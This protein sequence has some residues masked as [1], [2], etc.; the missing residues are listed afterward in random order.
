[1]NR[2]TI[3]S[4]W[5]FLF[6]LIIC[7]STT[8]AGVFTAED[9]LRTE[10]ISEVSISPDGK[11]V[12][13][14]ISKPRAASEKPGYPYREL[15]IY[16]ADKDTTRAFITGKGNMIDLKWRPIHHQLSFRMRRES[17]TTQIWMIPV[18]GGESVQ[19]S[20]SETSVQSYR[21]QPDGYRI[22]YVAPTPKTKKQKELEEKGYGFIFFEE[23]LRHRNLYL[24]DVMLNGNS[25]SPRQ[26]THDETVW[27]FEFNPDGSKML[28]LIS[29][30]NTVDQHH[31]FGKLHLLDMETLEQTLLIDNPGKMGMFRFSPDSR[32]IAFVGAKNQ[33]DHKESQLYC[34]QFKDGMIMNLTPQDYRGHVE[35]ADWQDD[36]TILYKSSEGVWSAL[37][38]VSLSDYKHKNLLH[39]K[40]LGL[41]FSSPEM[42]R[43]HKRMAFAG[44]SAEDPEQVY[45]YD[46]KDKPRAIT[47]I[48]PWM[49][50]KKLGEQQIIH[51]PAR[52]GYPVQ[53]LLIH[54]VI[55]PDS[56]PQLVVLV[57]GGPESHDSNDWITTY[58]RPGQALAGRGYLVFYP[59]YRSSTGYGL[60]HA[61]AGFGDPAGVEF[62]DI[63]DGIDYLVSTGRADKRRVGVAGSSYGG[64]A[65]AWFGT[66]YSEKVKAVCSLAG[67]SDLISKRGTSDI[68][69]ETDRVH[70]G[71]PLEQMWDLSLKRSPVYWAYLSRSAVLILHG[72]EDTR[73]PPSQGLELYRRLKMNDHPAVRMV[74]YPGEGHGNRMQTGQIDAC[75]R[76]LDWFDWYLLYNHPVNGPMP[77][78]DIHEQYGLEKDPEDFPED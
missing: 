58:S 34:Y 77:P 62:D 54:P 31:M 18:D 41:V 65:A 26:I 64:Y 52:D 14:T 25:T 78:L 1:M 11:Y 36:G 47:Q 29:P 49:K 10:R 20:H 67:V 66:Y 12:A 60:A 45:F 38:T 3:S 13:Y 48:N 27:T 71:K 63:A 15:Y 59:N 33:N 50:K 32:R 5:L 4:A 9:I 69:Y 72:L 30:E 19:I 28:A 51:Y 57:H 37:N 24:I 21:W 76:I 16:D 70:Y 39:G 43:K 68:P 23:D 73:V 75:Y 53:G 35:C 7:I 55:E 44:S 17:Q 46:G 74:Q 8:F 56:L 61:G 42:D 2:S 22:A 40:D 6:S